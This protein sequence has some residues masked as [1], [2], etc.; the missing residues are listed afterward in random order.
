MRS[1][2][3]VALLLTACVTA[4]FEQFDASFDP[5]KSKD[6]PKWLADGLVPMEYM[7]VGVI[8][9]SH[10]ASTEKKVLVDKARSEGKRLGCELV[11]P[12]P[13]PEVEEGEPVAKAPDRTR[14]V[15]A[16]VRPGGAPPAVIAP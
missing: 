13:P 15:C 4:R 3:F 6:D 8:D 9:L 7:L 1:P 14:F 11:M 12:E 16:V 10:P 2:L 5:A